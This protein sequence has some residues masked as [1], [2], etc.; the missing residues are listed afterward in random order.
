MRFGWLLVF[1]ILLGSSSCASKTD[2]LE[3]KSEVAVLREV[4]EEIKR[5]ESVNGAVMIRS[6]RDIISHLECP[7]EDVRKLVSACALGNTGCSMMDIERVV[8]TMTKMRHV[9]S[10]YRPKDVYKR[11]H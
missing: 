1:V 11:Q 7:Q 8:G 2:M 3:I 5:S 6:F 9:V 10:Y 4:V